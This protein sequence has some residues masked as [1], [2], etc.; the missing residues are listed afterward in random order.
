MQGIFYG[1]NS[2]GICFRLF[3]NKRIYLCASY[4]EKCAASRAG[5]D[6]IVAAAGG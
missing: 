2:V 3:Y 4:D 1:K 5:M 6:G